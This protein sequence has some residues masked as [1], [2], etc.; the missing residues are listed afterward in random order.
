M[1]I[2]TGG[3][4]AMHSS[5][6]IICIFLLLVNECAAQKSLGINGSVVEC[7]LRLSRYLSYLE[8]YTARV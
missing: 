8:S 6:Y 4:S 3:E 2:P 1:S 5:L 7:N